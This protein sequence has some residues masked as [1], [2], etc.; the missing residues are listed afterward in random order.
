MSCPKLPQVTCHHCIE[1]CNNI[2]VDEGRGWGGKGKQKEGRREG[3]LAM[4]GRGR[5]GGLI[6]SVGLRNGLA[7]HEAGIKCN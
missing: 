1:C 2:R 7:K 3:G 5:T 6:H 4:E